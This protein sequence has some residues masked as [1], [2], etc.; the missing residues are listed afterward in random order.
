MGGHRIRLLAQ[1]ERNQA[2]GTIA[3]IRRLV[4]RDTVSGGPTR[5][6][7]RIVL[8]Y[9]STHGC[10]L[11]VRRVGYAM[12]AICQVYPKQQTFLDPVSTSHLCQEPTFVIVRGEHYSSN[13]EAPSISPRAAASCGAQSTPENCR[14]YRNA[15]CNS[16]TRSA[17]AFASSNRPT[18]ASI[19]ARST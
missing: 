4:G 18:F 3:E 14:P 8:A 15:G 7:T 2:R 9:A 11:R 5:L 17:A 13:P 10:R 12:L 16:K 6:V 1:I 19:A